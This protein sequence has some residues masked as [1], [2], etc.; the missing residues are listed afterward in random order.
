MSMAESIAQGD[1]YKRDHFA[2]GA[3]KHDFIA[4]TEPKELTWPAQAVDPAQV[5]NSQNKTF[6]L[7]FPGFCG[8]LSSLHLQAL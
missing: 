5:C 8:P 1:P 4:S 7:L 3:G 6:S 2:F